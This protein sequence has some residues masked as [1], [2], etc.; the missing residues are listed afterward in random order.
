MLRVFVMSLF[1]TFAPT[2]LLYLGAFSCGWAGGGGAAVLVPLWLAFVLWHVVMR[3][4]DWPRERAYWTVAVG[5]RAGLSVVVM[6]FL[7]G[8]CL[9]L[10]RGLFLLAPLP[11]PVWVGPLLALMATPLQRL[12]YN[13]TKAARIEAFLE[14]AVAQ[15]DGKTT[16]HDAAAAAAAADVRTA[17]GQGRTDLHALAQRHGPAPVLDALSALQ[18]DGLLSPPLARAL[19]AWACDPALSLDLQ[20]LEAPY[21]TLSLVQDDAGLVIDFAHACITLLEA[22]PEAFWDCPSNRMLRQVQQRHAATEAAAAVRA[23]RVKQLCL[24]RARMSQSRA[25][26][27]ALMR[28]SAD[29]PAP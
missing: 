5:L 28:E 17:L 20:G 13:P 19:I 27:L 26:L 23:L 6:L 3:P 25:E 29:N 12:V 1:V 10:G 2:L 16:A 11:L 4:G 9:T 21:V 15:I 24:T 8:A 22:D 14:D 7:A 18:D